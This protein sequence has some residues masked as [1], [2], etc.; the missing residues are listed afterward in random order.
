MQKGKK[1]AIK[2]VLIFA[3]TAI[4][5]KEKVIEDDYC[6]LGKIIQLEKQSN[7]NAF[8]LSRIKS[9]SK[10]LLKRYYDFRFNNKPF[11]YRFVIDS[12]TDVIGIDTSNLKENQIKWKF[13]YSVLDSIFSKEDLDEIIDLKNVKWDSTNTFFRKKNQIAIEWCDYNCKNFISKPYY[14]IKKNY[15]FVMQSQNSKVNKTTIHIFKKG[16]EDWSIIDKIENVG[17]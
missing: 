6:F 17:W 1:I 14:N 9:G 7:N 15:A 2:M 3:L 12:V 10:N 5:C 11:H 8:G 16:N 4:S 13:K